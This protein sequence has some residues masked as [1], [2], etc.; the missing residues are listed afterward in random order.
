MH[1]KDPVFEPGDIIICIGS[2]DYNGLT[3][4]KEYI[5]IDYEPET[6]DEYFT[7]PAYV[8][9]YNNDDKLIVCHARRFIKKD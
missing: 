9:I 5:V 7:W 2:R 1:W 6:P 8:H 3:I 4:N